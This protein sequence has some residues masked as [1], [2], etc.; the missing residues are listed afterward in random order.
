MLRDNVV[1]E[2]IVAVPRSL[3]GDLSRI[4]DACEEEGVRL[5]F[6]ANIYDFDSATISCAL[7]DDIPLLSYEPV[8]QSN[9]KLIFKRIF[10]LIVVICALPVL[11]PLFALLAL[12]IRLD[13]PG[14]AMFSQKRVGLRKR[15]FE[16][17]KFRSMVQD[18]EERMKEVEH[19]NE[20][21]GPNFKIEHDPRITRLGR[22][23]RRTSIDELPQVFNVLIG[24]MSLVGPRPMSIRDVELFDKGIQRKRFSVRPGIT[25]LWQVSGRSNLTFDEWLEL[26]L[27]YIGE[28]S[29]WLD[30]KILLKTVPT[31]LRGSGAV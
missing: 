16:L 8:S 13:S 10:D 21:S 14:P 30:F 31:V 27:K 6:M 19:L 26:D 11:L 20:A 29:L 12:A 9:A 4:V 18:A 15:Q 23:I 2:V 25:C 7:V 5:R 1:D 28:W 24:D 17:Y 3:L 22:F